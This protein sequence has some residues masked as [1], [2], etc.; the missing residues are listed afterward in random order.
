MGI[1]VYGANEYHFEDRLLAHLKA[2]IGQKL[3]RQECFF[4][5]WAGP[6]EEGGERVSLWLSPHLELAFRFSEQ[7]AVELNGIWVKTLTT[8][9][10]THRGLVVISEED[11]E[12]IAKSRPEVG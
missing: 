4:L 10:H 7:Q 2:A 11:A 5:S 3:R 12:R 6:T 8:M 1:L 9:A